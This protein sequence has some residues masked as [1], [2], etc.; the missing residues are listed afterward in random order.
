MSANK[1]GEMQQSV[2]G[3]GDFLAGLMFIGFGLL[4]LYLSRD[5][6]MGTASRMGPGYFPA[7][8]GMLICLLGAGVLLRGLL[9]RAQPPRNFALLQAVLVLSAIA[10][11]A[12][13]VESLGIVVAV[14]LVV[15][16]SSLAG[17]TPRWVE[18]ALLAMVMVA[19]AVGMFT[20]G[21]DLPFKVWPG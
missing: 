21:L 14:A 12:A 6:P 9:V 2:K 13:T 15:V 3:T 7:I 8:L 20:Y 1:G 19:L 4:A 11:F 5:Y 10:L 17:G 18:V 16:I